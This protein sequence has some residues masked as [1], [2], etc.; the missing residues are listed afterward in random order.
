MKLSG[1]IIIL[2]PEPSLKRYLKL[3]F[4]QSNINHINKLRKKLPF[5]YPIKYR[6]VDREC[7][8]GTPFCY[9]E[10]PKQIILVKK[11]LSLFDNIDARRLFA[12]FD[13]KN[14]L[15]EYSPG[16][17]FLS[18]K[19][20]SKVYN[21]IDNKDDFEILEVLENEKQ[22]TNKTIGFD[23]GGEVGRFSIISDA[24]IKPF[25][26]PPDINDI[27]D[28][29]TCLMK[30]NQYSLFDSMTDAFAYM[31]TYLTKDWGEKP[32]NGE[33]FSIFQVRTL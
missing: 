32:M 22:T 17:S 31:Q 7:I 28:L 3:D 12:T 6:G 27:E 29:V 8:D 24:F 9:Y 25:W 4:I 1:H 15:V 20:I 23:V 10:N 19:E 2:K 16:L 30:L 13:K 11:E 5:I 26:H 33:Q 21:L 18:F 14:K